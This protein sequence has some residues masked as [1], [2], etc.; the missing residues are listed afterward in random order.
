MI[1]ATPII[2]KLHYHFPDA[3]ID[4]LLKKGNES[5]FRDH[6]KLRKII[7]WDKSNNKYL[8][9]FKIIK[10]IRR[11][12]YDYLI[13][14][15]RFTSS[16]IITVFSGAKTTIGFDK[17]P[18]SLFFNKKIKHKI[19][20]KNIH[21]VE[22][23]LEL[24]RDITDDSTFNVKLYPSEADFKKTE[25]Y[26]TEKYICIAPAS[27]WYTKQFPAEKW[28]EFIKRT[29]QRFKIFLLGSTA[30]KQLCSDI[31]LAAA[32]PKVVNLAGELNLLE[33]AALMKDAHMNFVNDSAP[34]HIASAMNAP[35][36]SIFCSTIPDFGFGP[37]SDDSVVIETTEKLNC[38]PCGLHGLKECPEKHFKCALSISIDQLLDRL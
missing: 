3:I 13:N 27:L 22:R 28:I 19:G 26:K 16:G 25:S 15:Q 24:I 18:L 12:K 11:D 37:L 8:N 23:N 4:F 7:S 6:P 14:I 29:G 31:I 33:T 21:E 35:I 38:R 10:S 1:L 2:E 9:L 17:N 5:L 20:E 36:T 30:D 34:Q 32:N